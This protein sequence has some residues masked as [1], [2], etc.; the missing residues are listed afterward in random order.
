MSF[1]PT[2][3]ETNKIY[4]DTR[5]TPLTAFISRDRDVACKNEALKIIT[6]GFLM[7]NKK[8]LIKT[9]LSERVLILIEFQI[10]YLRNNRC[11]IADG[12]LRSFLSITCVDYQ[13]SDSFFT[14]SCKTYTP[15]RE[16]GKSY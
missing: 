7:Y 12:I 15:S 9:E 16:T 14:E 13:K 1:T 10:E 2:R 4:Y 5:K 3:F 6:W 11:K 8:L